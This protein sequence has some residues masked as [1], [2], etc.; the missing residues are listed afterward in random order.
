MHY[1]LATLLDSE[2]GD[3]K[4]RTTSDELTISLWSLSEHLCGGRSLGTAPQQ[5][6]DNIVNTSYK[7]HCRLTDWATNLSRVLLNIH[8]V[9]PQDI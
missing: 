7:S 3:M 4:F 9:L 1:R 5:E 8:F 2:D 6:R